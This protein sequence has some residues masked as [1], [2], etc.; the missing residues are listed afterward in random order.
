LAGRNEKLSEAAV[1][2]DQDVLGNVD[3]GDLY[4]I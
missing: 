4:C 3:R 1:Q 2:A